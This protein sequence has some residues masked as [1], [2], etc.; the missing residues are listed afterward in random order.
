VNYDYGGNYEIGLTVTD[1][2]GATSTLSRPFSVMPPAINYFWVDAPQAIFASNGDM[3]Y[4]ELDIPSGVK[5]ATVTLAPST[6]KESAWL[7]VRAGTP[8][9]LH[10]QFQSGMGNRSLR[11]S[12]DAPKNRR[13]HAQALTTSSQPRSRN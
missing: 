13:R 2:N 3:Q 9:V 12:S 10:P 4:Y 7:Y 5:G 8:S 11:R 6:T 1:S